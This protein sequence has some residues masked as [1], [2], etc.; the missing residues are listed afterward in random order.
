MM[1][2]WLCLP[3]I[4]LQIEECTQ[5]GG[6]SGLSESLGESYGHETGL[7]LPHLLDISVCSRF[8][9]HGFVFSSCLSYGLIET[10]QAAIPFRATTYKASIRGFS[11][12]SCVASCCILQVEVG[13]A[14]NMLRPCKTWALS[15]SP[16]EFIA[17]GIG[18]YT[19]QSVTSEPDPL[20]GAGSVKFPQISGKFVQGCCRYV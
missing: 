7:G 4:S 17:P 9:S 14:V 5:C 16:A 6:S 19:Y 12:S 2:K 8:R 3:T 11:I 15:N 10:M 20:V 13:R 18:L 1:T